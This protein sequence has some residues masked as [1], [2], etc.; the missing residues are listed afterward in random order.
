MSSAWPCAPAVV[1]RL[2]GLTLFL[3]LLLL[4]PLAARG[5]CKPPPDIPNAKPG[6]EGQTSFSD[7]SI[8]TYKCEKGF[9]KVPGMPD[10]VICLVDKWST[11]EEFC[12]RSCDV[13][14][15]LSFASLKSAYKKQN[16]F[17]LGSVVE[18]ECRRGFNREHS[19]SENITCLQNFTWSKADEF[20]KK[21]S[22]PQPG[23]IING[24]VNITTDILFGALITFKCD[25]G[26]ELVG[27]PFSYCV[28]VGENVD[29][30]DPLPQCKESPPI[31]KVTP[32]SQR[33]TTVNVPETQSPHV[34]MAITP[35]HKRSTPKGG[36]NTSS[37]VSTIAS[38]LVAGTIVI[39]TLILFK[40]FWDCG[41]RGT[42]IYNTDS[43]AYDASSHWLADLAKEEIRRKCTQVHR[44][45]LVSYKC[46]EVWTQYM[47]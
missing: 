7:Q 24:H 12:N 21:K 32:T 15:R 8:V 18:Y 45:F 44:T 42:H 29:W 33:P 30:S 4:C 31:S 23:G 1:R 40:T 34:P 22:C 6:L 17:P 37:G 3:L 10:S 43:F 28:L 25:A 41:R 14:T 11:I 2:G 13:P 5:D 47:Q 19:L 46:L 36:G 27:A 38:G 35:F 9:V 20:C 39:V 16:Y 26:Y